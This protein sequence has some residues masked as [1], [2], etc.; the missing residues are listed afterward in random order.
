MG[1]SHPKAFPVSDRA[2]RVRT[3]ANFYRFSEAR[4][5]RR[6]S[7]D[8]HLLALSALPLIVAAMKTVLLRTSPHQETCATRTAAKGF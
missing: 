7:F 1:E 8:D 6:H 4:N 2:N 3:A 5:V